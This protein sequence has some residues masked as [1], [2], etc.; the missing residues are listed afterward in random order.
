[1]CIICVEFQKNQITIRE[2]YSILGE[3]AI[4]IDPDHLIEVTEMLEEAEK[5]ED[6]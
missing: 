3:V 5:N 1:M 4:A 6:G 2:A